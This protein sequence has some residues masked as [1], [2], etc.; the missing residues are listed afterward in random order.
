M[1][2]KEWKSIMTNTTKPN[3]QTI[4]GIHAGA[5]GD[6]HTLFAKHNCIAVGWD[7]F[8]DLSKLP[9]NRDDFKAEYDRSDG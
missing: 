8:G 3:Y 7:T 2:R 9:P 6:T 1:V 4:W 5:T